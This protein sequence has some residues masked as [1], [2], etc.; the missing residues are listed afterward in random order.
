VAEG[1]GQDTGG[2]QGI[3]LARHFLMAQRQGL[4]L[5]L[6]AVEEALGMRYSVPP[7]R[8]RRAKE[9]SSEQDSTDSQ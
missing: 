8:R 9:A 7:R 2:L 5:Q 1:E 4:I 6:R 3:T